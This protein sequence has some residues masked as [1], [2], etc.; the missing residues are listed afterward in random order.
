MK[1]FHS[2]I[3]ALALGAASITSVQAHDS[4]GIGFNVGAPP[5]VFYNPP[6]VYNSALPRYYSSAPVVTY[7]YYG[8]ERRDYYRGW[9]HEKREY[10]GWGY[11][12]K[13]HGGSDRHGWS[14]DRDD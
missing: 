9:G 11:E 7:Q 13:G 5:V 2:R 10:R 14:R 1:I 12:R 3:L 8:D 4:L 6:V